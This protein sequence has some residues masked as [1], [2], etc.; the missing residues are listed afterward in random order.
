MS[1]SPVTTITATMRYVRT[2]PSGHLS[3]RLQHRS[4]FMDIAKQVPGLVVTGKNFI[5]PNEAVKGYTFK[6]KPDKLLYDSEQELLCKDWYN[7]VFNVKPWEMETEECDVQG[8]FFAQVVDAQHTDGPVDID[9]SDDE[10]E[11][12]ERMPSPKPVVK[13]KSAVKSKSGGKTNSNRK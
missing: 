4:Q 13:A 7:V 10:E 5:M 8:G 11:E 1:T 12:K 6:G 9:V 3:F 2:M